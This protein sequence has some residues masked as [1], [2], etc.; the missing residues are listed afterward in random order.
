LEN[1][2]TYTGTFK[3]G[4]KHGQGK[5]IYL[6]SGNIFEG[7]FDNNKKNGFGEMKWIKEK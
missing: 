5:V 6:N 7:N 2:W 3:E 4:N 1:Q